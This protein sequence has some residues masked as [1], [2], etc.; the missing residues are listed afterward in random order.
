MYVQ[1]IDNDISAISLFFRLEWR[2]LMWPITRFIDNMARVTSLSLSH[3]IAYKPWPLSFTRPPPRKTFGA[4]IDVSS[5]FRMTF[6]RDGVGSFC[7][8]FWRP[9]PVHRTPSAPTPTRTHATVVFRSRNSHCCRR[10]TLFVVVYR[11]DVSIGVCTRVTCTRCV[12]KPY[13]RLPL[14]GH[15]VHDLGPLFYASVVRTTVAKDHRGVVL[16]SPP[17]ATISRHDEVYTII[18]IG[19]HCC[20]SIIV[21]R[22]ASRVSGIFHQNDTPR[23]TARKFLPV[24][25]QDVRVSESL[26]NSTAVTAVADNAVT[27]FFTIES[28]GPCPSERRQCAHGVWNLP[29]FSHRFRGYRTGLHDRPSEIGR[30]SYFPRNNIWGVRTVGSGRRLFGISKDR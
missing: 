25:T 5:K 30:F 21:V 9:F 22:A 6:T 2:L 10:H 26:L 28:L 8:E 27:D 3:Y 20:H 11:R 19:R 15:C 24:S 16:S 23:E 18:V 13:R 4:G 29:G 1:N 14:C 12:V 7:W 17:R